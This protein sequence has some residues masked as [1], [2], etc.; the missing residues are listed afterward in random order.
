MTM[1]NELDVNDVVNGLLEQIGNLSREIAL[2][3][4]QFSIV[5][6]QNAGGDEENGDE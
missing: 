1:N 4:V 6:K 5:L 2:L 3:R